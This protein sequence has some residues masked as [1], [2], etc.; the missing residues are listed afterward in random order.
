[1]PLQ[2]FTSSTVYHA[3]TI[4]LILLLGKIIP[5]Y[6]RYKEKKLVCVAIT[7]PLSTQPSSYSKYTQLNIRLS[8]NVRSISNTK[9]IFPYYISF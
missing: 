3:R 4:A 7:T 9:Y 1:M 6:S 5:S 8:Y 2:R